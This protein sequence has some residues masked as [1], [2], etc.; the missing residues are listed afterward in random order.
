M[1]GPSVYRALL[2]QNPVQVHGGD[3][4]ANIHK[5]VDTDPYQID[6]PVREAQIRS[7]NNNER[8]ST[9]VAV[10]LEAVSLATAKK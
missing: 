5:I 10:A 7:A 8:S 2:V 4:E 6:Q 3:C 1:Y 9:T